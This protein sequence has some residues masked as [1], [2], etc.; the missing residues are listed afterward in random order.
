MIKKLVTF[1]VFT[2]S[3]FAYDATVEIV[4]KMDRLPRIVLQDASLANTEFSF[5]QKFHKILVG[6]LRVSSH[7]EVVNEYLQSSF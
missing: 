3:L 6:D 7:F 5:R 1:V 4:K 2:C